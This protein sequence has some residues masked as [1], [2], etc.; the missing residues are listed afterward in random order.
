MRPVDSYADLNFEIQA[1]RPLT[2]SAEWDAAL[3]APGQ[4][5]SYQTCRD[6]TRYVSSPILDEQ[7]PTGGAFCMTNNENGRIALVQVTNK[8]QSDDPSYYIT[9]DI[10]IWQGPVT[11]SSGG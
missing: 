7:L 8:A 10:T 11:G 4:A 3:L 6:D 1:G 9:L 2:T 5:R